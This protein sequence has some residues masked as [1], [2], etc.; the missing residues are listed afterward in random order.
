MSFKVYSGSKL[1]LLRAGVKRILI[2]S[3]V[4]LTGVNECVLLV[5]WVAQIALPG[6]S[7]PVI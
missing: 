5:L 3:G 7:F 6:L 2:A 4:M 1:F